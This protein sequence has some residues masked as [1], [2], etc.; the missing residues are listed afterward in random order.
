MLCEGIYLFIFINFVFYKGFFYEW[1]FYLGLAW[2]K[3]LNTFLYNLYFVLNTYAG[4]PMP[5]VAI[6]AGIS[7]EHYGSEN[8][9]VL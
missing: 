1:Y 2:G 3:S 5:I 9:L 6:A 8:G 4:L 7:N